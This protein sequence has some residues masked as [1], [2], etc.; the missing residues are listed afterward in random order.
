[1]F[2]ENSEIANR[3]VSVSE[4]KKKMKCRLLWYFSSAPPRGLGL[5]PKGMEADALVFGRLAHAVLEEGYNGNRNFT[6]I[7][8]K[9]M[10]ESRPSSTSLFSNQI[11]AFNKLLETGKVMFRGY[12]DWSEKMDKDTKF[13]ATETKWKDIALPGV[14]STISAIID[15]VIL[16]PDGLW[17]L[18]FKTTSSEKNSWTTQDLQA[19]MYTYAGREVIDKS[20]KGVIFRFL[21]KKAPW[22]YDKLIL[23][24]FE[25]TTRKNVA[26]LTTYREY[27]R[28]IAVSTLLLLAQQ[29]WKPKNFYKGMPMYEYAKLADFLV[30]KEHEEFMAHY[31]FNQ[32]QYYDQIQ[33]LRHTNQGYY[34]DVLVPRS[35]E[36][37][38]NYLQH[39]IIPELEDLNNIKYIGPTGLANGWSNCGRCMFK[40]PCLAAMRGEDYESILEQNFEI[41]DHYLEEM[42]GDEDED[43]IQA[44]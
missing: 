29:G 39:V 24:K 15:A 23:K 32:K 25:V 22:T 6:E 44:I 2:I 19:T 30:K 42:G 36:E 8:A 10:E 34:W 35:D 20:I 1:M 3:S 7:Y 37:I 31:K 13:L 26:N 11:P 5:S 17:L 40:E 28:A 14:D 43:E 33:Q 16:R 9:K 21:L 4:L 27:L 12:E 18:D 41:S 38:N